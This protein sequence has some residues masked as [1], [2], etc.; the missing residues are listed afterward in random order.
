[1]RSIHA[2]LQAQLDASFNRLIRMVFLNFAGDPV[3]I[4]TDVGDIVWNPGPLPIPVPGPPPRPTSSTQRTFVGVGDLG[5]ISGIDE[6]G[7]LSPDNYSL[8]LTGV[9]DE[10]VAH[11]RNL[12]HLGRDAIIWMAARD[13][14]TGQL[15]G[16]PTPLIRGVMDQ[17]N[18]GSGDAG[19]VV[20]VVISDERS[21]LARGPGIMF[22]HAQQQA[23]HPVNPDASPVPRTKADGFFRNVAFV[24]ER[25]VEWVPKTGQEGT[26]S[27][28]G[29][30]GGGRGGGPPTDSTTPRHRR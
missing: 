3:F 4:H 24:G 16:T 13:L 30:G 29:P 15:I 1:M 27:T 12:D 11:A 22:S 9:E 7:S 20:T 6:D 5:G 28:G 25:Q 14:V 18:V 17:M 19:R 2:D 21:L 8:T 10:Y 23:R 26:P